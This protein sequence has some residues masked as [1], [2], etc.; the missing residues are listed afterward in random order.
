MTPRLAS[1][2]VDLEIELTLTK[3]YRHFPLAVRNSHPFEQ[4]NFEVRN[5]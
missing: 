3:R 4:Q 2:C 1:L 5:L